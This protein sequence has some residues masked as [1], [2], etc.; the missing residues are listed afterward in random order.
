MNPPLLKPAYNVLYHSYGFELVEDYAFEIVGGGIMT[1]P[2][3]FWF[4]GA[5]I[6]AAFWQVTYSPYD[7]RILPGALVHD[8][9]Y[10]SKHVQR[11]IA[12]AT[13]KKYIDEFN[14][15]SLKSDVIKLAVNLVGS[16]AW[17]DSPT[18]R[19][20]LNSLRAG[21]RFSGKSLAKYGL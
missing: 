11:N 4:N 10:T 8:W 13:L 1:I 18:D 2:A 5:S 6:P 9:L 3:T 20:Y 16:F 12:D 17:E 14:G 19:R 7:P 15:G 21:L